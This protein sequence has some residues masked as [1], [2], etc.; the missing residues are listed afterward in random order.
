MCRKPVRSRNRLRSKSVRTPGHRSSS[1]FRPRGERH[2]SCGE[3]SSGMI[4]AL[5]DFVFHTASVVSSGKAVRYI[6]P[7]WV[8]IRSPSECER[9]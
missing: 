9:P 8:R 6:I 4:K 3:S 5:D 2:A 1:M 7:V